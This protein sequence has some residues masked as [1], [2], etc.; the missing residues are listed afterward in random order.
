MHLVRLAHN[1][2]AAEHYPSIAPQCELRLSALDD[3]F[4]FT[5]DDDVLAVDARDS[6]AARH[7]SG[8]N[9]SID[10]CRRAQE[11][12][13]HGPTGIALI[14]EQD[15]FLCLDR[16]ARE[17]AGVECG[18]DACE[19]R[20]MRVRVEVDSNF[21]VPKR[22]DPSD[23]M[24]PTVGREKRDGQGRDGDRHTEQGLQPGTARGQHGQ[25]RQ[26]R[27]HREVLEHEDRQHGRGLPVTEPA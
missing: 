23:V 15:C 11:R 2:H 14:E 4:F 5:F 25:Q 17:H 21:A 8:R 13:H 7:P 6:F 3:D 10:R 26:I 1:V 24:P 12:D 27:R 9:R 16:G 22:D 19:Q 18:S 20:P